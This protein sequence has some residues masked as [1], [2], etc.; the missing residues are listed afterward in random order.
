MATT[1]SV[2]SIPSDSPGIH[3][4]RNGLLL[5]GEALATTAALRSES[6]DLIYM[7]PPFF[8]GR[9]HSSGENRFRDNWHGDLNSY[10]GWILPRLRAMRR[11]LKPTGTLFLHLD[12]HA[13]HYA[14]VELDRIFGRDQFINEIIWS[15]RTGGAS[16]RWLARK[17]DS[18]LF[19][20]KSQDYKFNK[21][22]ERSNLSHKY[23][24]SNAG[25]MTDEQGP[26]RLAIMRDVWEIP[27]LRGN[28]AERVQ[29]PT[30]K[31]LP[32][33][34][35][36]IELASEPGDLVADFLCGSG[37]TPVAALSMGRRFIA[38]DQSEMALNLTQQRIEAA[39]VAQ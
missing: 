30:Q 31:P 25:V 39:Q 21:L 17:H 10:I 19:Y 28:S 8:T 14:K 4:G 20:A 13:V 32:L 5:H 15:Y 7:D 2:E 38:G 11:L 37:T 18:I 12:W 16:G 3:P 24:F 1:K 34:K 33:L 35:R 22:K 26:Y 27:A 9:N 36:I 29:F 23:G 6:I